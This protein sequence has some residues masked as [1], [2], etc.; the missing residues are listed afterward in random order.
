M[1][2]YY[3]LANIGYWCS[4]DACC[5]TKLEEVGLEHTLV[6]H[7]VRYVML[8]R[9][10]ERL[11]MGGRIF[12]HQGLVAVYDEDGETFPDLEAAI[13]HHADDMLCVTRLPF[14]ST[15]QPMRHKTWQCEEATAF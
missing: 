3:T 5:E 15:P 2:T 7:H 14:H 12:T 11:D 10:G 1:I 8:N 13:R 9:F 4:L 6:V